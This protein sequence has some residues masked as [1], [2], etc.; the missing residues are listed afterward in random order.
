MTQSTSS[1]RVN[2]YLPLWHKDRTECQ[3]G[4]IEYGPFYGFE[5]FTVDRVDNDRES[6]PKPKTRQEMIN[7]MTATPEQS[8]L[9][10]SPS[11]A[12]VCTGATAWAC[13]VPGKLIYN[14]QTEERPGANGLLDWPS[15][16]D[17]ALDMR[18]KIRDETVNLGQSLVEYRQTAKMFRGFGRAV[19]DGW[20]LMHGRLP[21]RR[22]RKVTPCTVASA[23]L[24]NTYG[25]QPLASDLFD[26]Y[27]QLSARLDL[28][29][30]R[31]FH[32]RVQGIEAGQEAR[33]SSWTKCE[34]YVRR[35]QDAVCYVRFHP[36]WTKST[37]AVGNPA[38][39]AWELIPFSFVVDWGLNIG[40][41]LASLD[42]LS[43]VSGV[44]G[45]LTTK[46]RYHLTRITSDRPSQYG[47][48]LVQ[49]QVGFYD[50]TTHKRDLI[51]DIPLPRVPTWKP[52]RSWKTIMN[53]IALLTS[54]NKR[55]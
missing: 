36:N 38:E 4:D 46:H 10:K 1:V 43:S 53:G 20:K 37:L 29:I 19:K 31:R 23:H 42:A 40:D 54:V 30:Y 12:T 6:R 52:S 5:K 26:S 41:V 44:K 16:D 14:F 49:N 51:T 33:Y 21:R 50:L 47:R 11:I 28:P 13:G 9:H 18:L 34:G 3:Q 27:E 15:L 48:P 8:V 39:L 55:C 32:S 24:M 22:R 35:S 7:Q 25:I 45:T 17:W 2:N